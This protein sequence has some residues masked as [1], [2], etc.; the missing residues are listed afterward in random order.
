MPT[1]PHNTV[2]GVVWGAVGTGT[3]NRTQ[4]TGF[5]RVTPTW[6]WRQ[7]PNRSL[8]PN[9]ISQ[10]P[11]HE[12]NI[13]CSE[14]QS[15]ISCY[16]EILE[17]KFTRPI[18]RFVGSNIRKVL[19][20]SLLYRWT[21]MFML[22]QAGLWFSVLAIERCMMVVKRAIS[23][24]CCCLREEKRKEHIH[25]AYAQLS[26]TPSISRE[27]PHSMYQWICIW[28]TYYRSLP[29]SV[30]YLPWCLVFP[31]ARRL[32]VHPID[33][34]NQFISFAADCQGRPSWDLCE[35]SSKQ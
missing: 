23:M 25:S 1:S 24:G 28:Y 22:M 29:E 35:T 2:S 31:P 10:I 12:N 4:I 13:V 30:T 33:L 34:I 18:I 8:S 21:S 9:Q 19:R 26:V 14:E 27:Y 7:M 11:K 6:R 5:N 15:P 32:P 3:I 16:D 20:E 17:I